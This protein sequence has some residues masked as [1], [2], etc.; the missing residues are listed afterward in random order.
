M[1]ATYFFLILYLS[2]LGDGRNTGTPSRDDQPV[3]WQAGNGRRSTWNI[4]SSC[5]STTFACTWSVQH[6]NIPS[7]NDG[8]WARRW[9]SVKWMIITIL[10]PEFIVLHAIFEL[11]LALQALQLIG[12]DKPVIYPWWLRLFRRLSG[13]HNPDGGNPE[14]QETWTLTHCFFANMGGLYYENGQ[15]CFPLTAFQLAK[16]QERFENLGLTEGDIQDKSKQD[17]FAKGV[18][19]LQ[20]LQ[21]ALSLIVR[22]KQGLAFSQLEAITLGFAVCGAVI[23]LTYLYKPQNVET[24]TKVRPKNSEVWSLQYEKSFDSFWNVLVNEDRRDANEPRSVNKVD[25]KVQRIPRIPNDNIPISRNRVAHPGVFLLAFVSGLFGAMHAIA[26]KFEFPTM[27]ERILWQTAT[28]VAAGSP[29]VGLTTIPLTQV[30]VPWGNPQDFMGKCLRILR[31]FSWH[32]ADKRGAKRAYKALEEVYIQEDTD[33]LDAR[34]PYKDIFYGTQNDVQSPELGRQLLD[35]IERK[36]EFEKAEPLDL[37][38]FVPQFK[39]L[40]KLMD[41][42]APKR[43]SQ[44]AKTNVYPR[45]NM[46]PTAFNKCV[47]YLTGGLYCLARLSLLAVALSSLRW[48]P[49]SVYS[50]TPW[51][52]YIPS[53]GSGT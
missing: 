50:D 41:E 13:Y 21:L 7:A 3:A 53:L 34:K 5:L 38:D 35:F 16:E 22:T 46:L 4:I 17:W 36:R 8:K 12:K 11:A 49:D 40:L 29:M 28:V 24:H 27:V 2:A 30:T 1:I 44:K 43:L 15:S 37:P 18:A 19:A 45:E 6:L 32:V 20:L 42:E 10:F 23:Y 51:T 39:L 52:Y 9:R 14:S 47:L 26:W 33:N 25:I 31:E 48:M